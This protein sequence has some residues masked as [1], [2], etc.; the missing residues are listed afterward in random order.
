VTE[1]LLPVEAELP[2]DMKTLPAAAQLLYALTARTSFTS[3]AAVTSE[4]TVKSKSVLS[5]REFPPS[6][7]SKT[8]ELYPLVAGSMTSFIIDVAFFTVIVNRISLAILLGAVNVGEV[9]AT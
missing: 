3:V 4:G 9:T 8:T 5:A 1:T 7:R 2:G 6:A